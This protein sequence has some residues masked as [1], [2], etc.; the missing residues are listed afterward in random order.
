MSTFVICH[1]LSVLSTGVVS[2]NNSSAVGIPHT[3]FQ[4][5]VSTVLKENEVVIS[6]F[7]FHNVKLSVQR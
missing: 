3:Q 4:S 7:N 5:R 1:F 2:S 6:G